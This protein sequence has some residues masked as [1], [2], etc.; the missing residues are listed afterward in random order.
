MF[1]RSSL[2]LERAAAALGL[3]REL[4]WTLVCPAHCGGSVLLPFAAGCA[5]GFLFG[6]LA[7]ILAFFALWNHFSPFWSSSSA[8][9]APS[10]GASAAGASRRSSRLA[11]YLDEQRG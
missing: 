6:V 1:C 3:L 9:P 11:R 8:T 10:Y 4:S 2:V 5:V 7:S